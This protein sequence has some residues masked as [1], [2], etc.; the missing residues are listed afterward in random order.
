MAYKQEVV[1]IIGAAF[2]ISLG[3]TFLNQV[4]FFRERGI[5]SEIEVKAPKQ[6]RGT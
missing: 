4:Q 5:D 3:K 1:P 6:V 2:F